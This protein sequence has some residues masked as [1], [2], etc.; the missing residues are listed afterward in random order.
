MA[1]FE[2]CSLKILLVNEEEEMPLQ[3]HQEVELSLAS[4]SIE[5]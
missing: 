1:R 3:V 4:S 2:L 5:T